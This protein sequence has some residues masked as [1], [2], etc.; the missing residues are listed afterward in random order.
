MAAMTIDEALQQPGAK[1][2]AW[3]VSPSD[4]GLVVMALYAVGPDG[5]KYLA[6]ERAPEADVPARRA[7]LER[8][9]APF[10]STTEGADYVWTEDERGL[11]VYTTAALVLQASGDTLTAG[12]HTWPRDAL[13]R[14]IAFA[15]ENRVKRG[16]KAALKSGEEV[17]VLVDL[18]TA[19]VADPTYG[20]S[21]LL[22]DAEWVVHVAAALSQWAGLGK[23]ERRGI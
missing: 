3:C 5:A 20:R 8:R 4:D 10:A 1:V 13:A 19:A 23:I 11:T 22:F 15:T 18:S 14:V 17:D 12:E 9:G 21:E 16:V 6:G 7:E 2:Q